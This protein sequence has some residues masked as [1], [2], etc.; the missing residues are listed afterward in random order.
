[1]AIGTENLARE[2][3]PIRSIDI[4][5]KSKVLLSIGQRLHDE[6]RMASHNTA[7]IG[8]LI[9]EYAVVWVWVLHWS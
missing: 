3:E 5:S 1:M 2:K 9:A 4:E 8:V 7:R 6:N